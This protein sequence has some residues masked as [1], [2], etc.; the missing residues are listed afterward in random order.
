MWWCWI[1]LRF[2]DFALMFV[3][4]EGAD[5]YRT[6]NEAVRLWPDGRIEQLGW[7]EP[8]VEYRSGT[9]YPARATIGLRERGGRELDARDRAHGTHAAVRRARL[10]AGRRRLEPRPVDG[11]VVDTARRPRSRLS[12]SDNA[13]PGA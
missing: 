12:R 3:L 9:R 2:D 13:W 6:I 10:R 11:R 1:P 4:E 8:Q 7:A 5:G